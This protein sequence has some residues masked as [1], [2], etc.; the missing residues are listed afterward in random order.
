M[1]N[2][3]LALACI[4]ALSLAL[5]PASSR[6][7]HHEEKH[8]ALEEKMEVMDEAYKALRETAADASQNA[9]SAKHAA[10]MLASARAALEL[11]PA[12]TAAQPADKQAEFVAGFQKEIKALIGTLEQMEAAFRAGNN[13]LAN[14]LMG[15]I[16]GHR[17]SGH[18]DYKK[19][20]D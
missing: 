17:R 7:D 14:E 3:L 19:P 8:T 10:T 13:E 5:T 6:A 2:R 11:K 1:K 15:K 12:Y 9:A 18:G 4:T 20:R 16:R